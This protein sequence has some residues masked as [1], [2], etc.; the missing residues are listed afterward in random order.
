MD[1]KNNNFNLTNI[2]IKDIIKPYLVHWIWF[3]ISMAILLILAIFYIKITT[4][5]YM[6]ESSILIKDTKKGFSADGEMGVLQGL[7]GFGGMSTNSIENEVEV[8]K[9]KKLLEDVVKSNN[10]QTSI[11]IEQNLKTI[12]LFGDTAPIII[13]IANEKKNKKFPQYP[14]NLEVNGNK[15]LFSSKEFK[16]INGTL[17]SIIS[18]PFANIVIKKNPVFDPVKAGDIGE[19]FILSIGTIN[20]VVNT[21]QKGIKVELS[22]KDA[23]VLRLSMISSQTDKAQLVINNLVKAYNRDAINDKNSESEKTKGFIDERIS[24]I[25]KE[26]GEVES[27]KERFKKQNDITDI[28]TETKINLEVSAETKVKQLDIDSQ[29]EL[30]N[31]LI[32]YL[33]KQ[34]S[35]DVL[36]NNIGL[37]D[38]AVNNSITAYNQS[39]LERNRL[40]ETATMQN[41][42]VVDLTNQITSLKRSIG[43]SLQ[44]SKT[45]LELS[46]NQYVSELNN[47]G[48]KVSKVP[49]QEKIFRSIERQQQIKEN[50]YLLLL[51]KREET[52]I[53]LAVVAPKA[54]VLDLAYVSEKPVAP[55]KMIILFSA[56][57]FG[58]L[59]PIIVIYIKQLLNTKI[60]SKKDVNAMSKIPILA[61]IPNVAKNSDHL[62]Q[63]NDSSSLA[64]SFRILITNMNFLI[65]KD[66]TTKVIFVTSSIKGEGKT[67]VSINLA[68]TI[69][70][71]KNKVLLIGAD[72][73]NPQLQRYNKESKGYTG[74][75]EYLYNADVKIKDI[76]KENVFG[77]NLDVIFSGSIPPNPTELLG[78]GRIDNILLEAKAEGYN[79]VIIDTA[80]LLLVTDTFMIVEKGDLVLYVTRSGFSEKSLIE[81]ANDN[82]TDEKIKNVGFVLNDVK[83]QHYG[84]GNKYGYGYQKAR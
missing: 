28:P 58:L 5:S 46:R 42:L 43:E 72:I 49:Y 30:N 40:L 10:L 63:T 8:L 68:L 59:I 47:V 53:S 64:E 50:L 19:D 51:Q 7:S 76:I 54:R 52:A 81:F 44:K 16:D 56:L 75:T 9:T 18:L 25:S 57:V 34:S 62:V 55:K 22:D 29:L 65:P 24:I 26:L 37:K 78:N 67:F 14:I 79:Y 4:P 13:Y 39:V 38:I 12:E 84:Y 83:Q 69:V 66:K 17:N 27:D 71:P 35:N 61:E 36:P 48:Q 73:R 20:A 82:T 15:L 70:N 32:K 77:N 6:I 41:P 21:L 1:E 2:E 60:Y 80:P 11:F 23:T 45:G 3:V 31:V 33:N 74:L